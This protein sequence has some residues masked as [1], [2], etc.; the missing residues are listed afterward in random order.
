MRNKILGIGQGL[1]LTVVAL[2]FAS[3]AQAQTYTFSTLYSFQSNGKDPQ[4]S[5]APVTI[6]SAENLYGTSID[7]GDFG[8]GS[9]FKLTKTGV[10]SILHSFNGGTTD[11]ES[12]F[13]RLV[14]DVKGNLYGTTDSGGSLG[15]GAVFKLTPSGHETIIY[16]FANQADGNGPATLTLDSV[17]NIYGT[18]VG[19]AN[20]AGLVFEIDTH[21]TFSVLYAFCSLPGCADGRDPIGNLVLDS[22]G[23]IYGTTQALVDDG[24]VFKLTTAGVETVLH[25]FNGNDGITPDSLTAAAHG[26]LYGTTDGGGTH[27]QGTSFKLSENGG[28]LSTLYNFCALS[29]CKDGKDPEGPVRLDKSG[30]FYGTALQGANNMGSVVWEVSASGKI[31]VLHTFAKGVEV[32]AGLT[33]DSAGNLYGTTFDGGTNALG[34]VFKLTLVK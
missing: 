1:V 16:N 31:T 2:G 7:G 26:D 8:F 17:G 18:S 19:G 20:G 4:F 21:N 22:A 13:T 15:F 14:R 6:D 24:T 29:H 5:T 27:Q 12:P 30:N 3:A 10:F 32:M 9:V 25:S 33:M 23:N 11:G 34:S 28:S